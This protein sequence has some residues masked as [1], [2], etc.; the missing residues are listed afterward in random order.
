MIIDVNSVVVGD[1]IA[2][3]SRNPHDNVSWQGTVVGIA[4]W[5]VVQNMQSDLLPY[6]QEVKKVHH[7][8]DPISE[9]QFFILAIRQG[10]RTATQIVAKE[11]IEPT[12]LVKLELSNYIDVRI[13]ERPQEETQTILDLLAA[14]GYR[15]TKL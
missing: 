12:S 14:H 8:M 7:A 11:W 2:Y 10:E 15:A 13:F 4:S 3:K 1:I 6:Y 5:Q 9:L